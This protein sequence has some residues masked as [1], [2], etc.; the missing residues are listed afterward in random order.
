M[1]EGAKYPL[2]ILPEAECHPPSEGP[3]VRGT[4]P[5]RCVPQLSSLQPFPQHFSIQD[6]NET[7]SAVLPGWLRAYAQGESSSHPNN[8]PNLFCKDKGPPSLTETLPSP[9]HHRTVI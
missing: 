6:L 7:G 2:G 9:V 1:L 3:R 4:G 5:G 8:S